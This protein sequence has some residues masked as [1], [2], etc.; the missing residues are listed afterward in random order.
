MAKRFSKKDPKV[1]HKAEDYE[2]VHRFILDGT[3]YYVVKEN[4]MLLV[5]EL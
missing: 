2:V 1:G 5:Y 3:R 4:G